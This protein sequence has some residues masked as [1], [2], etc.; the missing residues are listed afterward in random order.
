MHG[1]DRERL[2]MVR[3]QLM[4]RNIRDRA[5]LEAMSTVPR[6]LF[7]PENVRQYAYEDRALP[8]SAG[9]TVSQPFIVAL[10]AQALMLTGNERVLEVGTGSGYAAAI[11]SLLTAEVYTIEIVPDLAETAR[12]AWLR[13]VITM[14]MCCYVMAHPGCPNMRP[15]MRWP[16][17]PL[18]RGCHN[19][20]A[21]NWPTVGVWLF[22]LVAVMISCCYALRARVR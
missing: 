13:S 16:W 6:H 2:N 10:M 22:L 19:P 5:V 18:R 21:S 15:M 14:C 20:C 4:R 7:L 17:R 1:M 3:K 12:H 8:L 11:L 9:Q